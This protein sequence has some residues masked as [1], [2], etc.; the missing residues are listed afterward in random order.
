MMEFYPD[1][2]AGWVGLFIQV[3]TITAALAAFGWRVIR[4]PLLT[5]INGLGERVHRVE[6]SDE[7]QGTR[8]HALER[9]SETSQ[10]D[11]TDLRDHIN[12]VEGQLSRLISHIESERGHKGRADSEIRER[13]VR[14]ETKVDDMRKH[15]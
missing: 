9:F 14:I 13:L 15:Q 4:A 12:R 3:S 5:S 10:R 8:L 7:G 2:L 11:R 6:M 1:T